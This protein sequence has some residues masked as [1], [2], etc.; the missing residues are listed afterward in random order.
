M[1]VDSTNK[2]PVAAALAGLME[3]IQAEHGPL[4]A[5]YDP[6]WRSPCEVGEP[7][8][9]ITD[10]QQNILW[11]PTPRHYSDDFAGL[12]NALETQVHPSIKTYYGAFW[13]AHLEAKAQD[14]PVSL[15]QVWNEE[16]R[17]RLIENLLGHHL[18]QKRAKGPLSLFFACTEPDSDLILTV[19]NDSGVVLLERPG[20][21]PL[22]QVSGSLAEFLLTLAPAPPTDV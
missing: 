10:G 14:G 21:K 11:Q 15:L 5:E 12:E 16:D 4:A 19:E 1:K 17:A 8:A 2:D 13:S 9:A 20:S 6:Q 22:R 18:I 3:R 7:F